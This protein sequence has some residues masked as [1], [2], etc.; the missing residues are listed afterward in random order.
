MSLP[1]LS[2]FQN[3]V[4]N[5][6]YPQADALYVNK[7]K[8]AGVTVY[9]TCTYIN[10][11]SFNIWKENTTAETFYLN[12]RYSGSGTVTVN[13]TGDNLISRQRISVEL[14]S[15]AGEYL[16][17]VYE[18]DFSYAYISWEETEN[19]KLTGAAWLA[20]CSE[21]A[22]DIRLAICIPTYKRRADISS[23]LALYERV[24][25]TQKGFAAATHLFVHNNDPDDD[26]RGLSTCPQVTII[27]SEAN[28]GGAGA[29][30]RCAH[31]AVENGYSHVL[32]MDDDAQ[33]HEE[34]WLR[35]LALLKCLKPEKHEYFIA[36]NCLTREDPLFCH[37]VREAIDERGRIKCH[38]IGQF[39][40]TEQ[41]QLEV[42]LSACISHGVGQDTHP[43]AAWWYCAIPCIAF[44]RYGW[45]EER[46][47]CF[48]DDIE[49]SLACKAKI[50]CC[51]GINVWHPSFDR[52][53]NPLRRYFSVRNFFFIRKKF[54]G[55]KNL[56]KSFFKQLYRLLLSNEFYNAQVTS[57]AFYDLI[58]SNYFEISSIRKEIPKNRGVLIS[59]LYTV[60]MCIKITINIGRWQNA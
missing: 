49:F 13:L 11:F 25:N 41:E 33:P 36:G 38:Q 52:P 4:F 2:C 45:P 57:K 42:A 40:L 30:N 51:N 53:M 12:L 1:G 3:I 47:F 54:F 7:A 60:C 22:H 29:F 46:F 19:F 50:I 55:K 5:D 16:L 26:L 37:A 32:F 9:D 23:T 24:I 17:P 15:D 58:E 21:P 34:A 6:F 48:G 20:K 8:G 10:I 31:L 39:Q 35:T 18:G 43:Y 27:N 56:Y 28:I 14:Q 59:A 44:Q